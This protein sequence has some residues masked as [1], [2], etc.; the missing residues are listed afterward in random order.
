[1]RINVSTDTWKLRIASLLFAVLCVLLPVENAF[2]IPDLSFSYSF[3][4]AEPGRTYMDIGGTWDGSAEVFN[5]GDEFTLT[6]TNS[7]VVGTTPAY[8]IRD[9]TV[10]VP[11]GFELASS[12]VIVSD[13]GCS[14]SISASAGQSSAG[15]PVTI[16][17]SSNNS[18]VIDLGCSYSFTF[19]LETDTT[20]NAGNP[21]LDYTLRYNTIDNNNGSIITEN[22]S[23]NISVNAGI[24]FVN[25][26]GPVGPVADGET[27]TF[28]V[29]IDN[30]GSGA[31]FDVLFTDILGQHFD[32]STLTLIPI[33]FSSPPVGDNQYTFNYIGPGQTVSLLVT[34]DVAVDIASSTC[35]ELVNTASVTDRTNS[36]VPDSIATVP[37]DMAALTISHVSTSRCVLCS[38]GTVT[39]R[40]TNSSGVD[41]DNIVIREDLGV[42]GL[43]VVSDQSRING[44]LI[45]NPSLSGTEYTWTLAAGDVVPAN[46]FIDL[47]FVVEYDDADGINEDLARNDRTIQASADYRLSCASTVLTVNDSPYLL[48]LDQPL[49]QVTKLA[50]NLDAGQTAYVPL[51]YGHEGD[52]VIWRVQIQNSGAIN[53]QDLVLDDTITS[54]FNIYYIC[55]SVTSANAAAVLTPPPVPAAP[56]GCVDY[57]AVFDVVDNFG[58]VLG[59][60]DISAGG[61]GEFFY[62]GEINAQCGLATN[63]V[64]IQ[65]GC[66]AQSPVGGLDSAALLLGGTGGTTDTASAD[67]STR[68]NNGLS[69]SSIIEHSITGLDGNQ[70]V[71]SNGIVTITVRNDSGGTIKGDS[72]NGLLIDVDLPD[73]YVLDTTYN[74]VT[75]PGGF[76]YTEAYGSSYSGA[77]DTITYTN[78][79][80][81]LLLNN[82][83]RFSLTSS[84]TGDAPNSYQHLFRH[85]DEFTISFRIV[86]VDQ[87][88]F[89]R[90]A[91]IDVSPEDPTT[92]TA[93]APIVP[94]DPGNSL[95]LTNSLTITYDD[96]C[97]FDGGT[98]YIENQ[99]FNVNI[100]D[101]DLTMSSNIYVL[102]ETSPVNLDVT[103]TNNGGQ[104]AANYFV[105]VTFGDAMNVLSAPSGCDPVATPLARPEWNVPDGIYSYQTV[106]MC[107]DRNVPGLGSIAPGAGQA[108]TLTFTVEN[109]DTAVNDDLTFRADV[110]GEI[111]LFNGSRMLDP[112]NLPLGPITTDLDASPSK[113]ITPVAHNYTQDAFRSRVIGFNLTKSQRI[114]CV[115]DPPALPSPVPTLPPAFD[116][117]VTI[118]EDC[119]FHIDAGG[120]FGFETPGFAL[121]AVENIRVTD[122]LPDGQGYIDHVTN[123]TSDINFVPA[124]SDLTKIPPILGATASLDEDDI[125]WEFGP[126]GVP[127]TNGVTSK[128]EWFRVDLTTRILNDGVDISTGINQH[129][130]TSTNVA[131]ATFTAVFDTISIDVYENRLP[132]AIPGFPP[133]TD[134]TI[135]LTVTEPNI[136]VTKQ[137]CNETLQASNGFDCIADDRFTDAVNDGD[138]NDSYIYRISLTNVA[139]VSGPQRAPAYN[140]IST[141]TLG[142]GISDLMLIE[143]FD[144]DNLDNDGDGLTEADGDAD[145]ALLFSS[146]PDNI[147]GN[148]IP[149][150]ITVDDSYSAALLRVD[151]GDSVTFYYRVNPD[152][153]IAPLQT[154]TNTVTMSYDSLDGAYG[155]QNPPQIGNVPVPPDTDYGRARLYTTA[156]EQAN[157]QMIPLVA[158]QKA[159]DELSNTLIGGS[160]QDVVVGEEIR[161]QLTAQLP[162]AN[163]RSFKIRDELP[164]GVRCIEVPPI[165]L[166]TD[167]RYS[168][169]GFDP[170][171]A[172]ISTSCTKSGTNDYVEWDFGDQQL[173]TGLSTRFDF[174]VDF[175][176]RVENSNITTEG[177]L[178]TNGGGVVDPDDCTG[179]VAVCYVNESGAPIALDFAPVS[180]VVR[181]PRITLTK[182]FS[183]GGVPLTPADTVDAGDV[184]TVTV[185]A[186]NNTPDVA[187]YNLRV[188]DAL[189]GTDL[190]YV[191][192]K[193]G[194]NP[195]D[196]VDTTLGIN[197]PIF[198]WNFD[199]A[200][201]EISPGATKTFTFDVRVDV[202]AQPL[203]TIDNTIQAIWDSIRKLDPTTGLPIALSAD[204]LAVDGNE[205]GLRNGV[206]PN[207][208]GPLNNY[209]AEADTFTS[210]RPLTMSK[211]DLDPSIVPTIGAHKHFQI[212]ILLP[213]GTTNNL[214]VT[215]DLAVGNIS[216]VLANNDLEFDITYTFEGIVSINDDTVEEDSFTSFPVENAPTS[217]TAIWIIGKVITESEVAPTTSAPRIVID[218][219]ARADNVSP[220]AVAGNTLQ[221]SVDVDY[222]HGQGG[223]AP[224]L[225]DTTAQVTVE[226]PLLTGSKSFVN[227][228]SPGIA[229]DA[230][231][232]I[233]Y[234]VSITNADNATTSTAYDVN[235]VD[236]LPPEMVLDTSFPIT[237]IIIGTGNV[238]GFQPDPA[239]SPNGPLIWGRGNG[240]NSIFIDPNDTLELTYRVELLNTVE[241]N[242]NLDNTVWFDWTSLDSASSFETDAYERTGAG[243]PTVSDPNTY[244]RT[245]TE[246]ITIIDDNTV[247]KFIIDDSYVGPLS[248]AVDSTVRIGDTV[249]YQLAVTLQEGHTDNVILEDTLPA[250]LEFVAVKE[251]NGDPSSGYD[252]PG[253]G[254]GSNFIYATILVDD[255]PSNGDTGVLTWNLGSITNNAQ[256]D[257]TTTDT[258]VIEYTAR[259]AEGPS[260]PHVAST[261][262]TNTVELTYIDGNGVL[263]DPAVTPRLRDT[264]DLTVLQPIIDAVSK[265]D[266]DGTPASN[267]PINNLAT[268][269][270]NFRL[271]TCN[272]NGLAPAYGI[273]II[274]DLP[275][276]MDETSITGPSNGA[277]QPDVRINGVLQTAGVDYLYTP[278]AGR[279]GLMTFTILSPVNPNECVDIDFDMGFYTD[280]GGDQFWTNTVNL[281]EYWS[282]PADAGQ[283]YLPGVSDNF[284][285]NNVADVVPP[286]KSLIIPA[287]GE[288]TI[289]DTVVYR[290]S[291]PATPANG[292]LYDVVITDTLDPSLIF[293]SASDT[294]ASN[295]SLTNNTALPNQVSLSI[296]HIPAGQQAIIELQARVNNVADANATDPPFQNTVTY[297]YAIVDGGDSVDLD[298]TTTNPLRIVEPD[299]TV[300]KSVPAASPDAGDILIYTLVI[301][302]LG[303]A[304][305]DNYSDAF[306]LSINDTLGLGLVYSG[307]PTFNGSPL[308]EPVITG[309]GITTPQNILW[310][311]AN[312]VDIDIPEGDSVTITYDVLVLDTVLAFQNLTNFVD[313][314]WTS[315]NDVDANERDGS[316]TPAHNDYRATDSESLLTPDNNN[317]TKR[318]TGDTSPV[319]PAEPPPPADNHVRI[320]DIIDFELRLDLQEGT[321]PDVLVTDILPLGF[322]FEETISINGVTTTTGSYDPPASGEGS[323]FVYNSIPAD[324]VPAEGA[325]GVVSWDFGDIVNLASGDAT[326]DTLIIEYRVRV[327]N[328]VLPQANSIPLTNSV[329]LDYLTATVAAP[330]TS[331]E[332]MTV[333]QPDLTVVK[334]ATEDSGNGTVE[335]GE[336]ITYTVEIANTGTT[337]AYDTVLQDI[338]P[339]GLRNGTAT[340]TM[341]RIELVSGT[342]LPDLNTNGVLTTLTNLDPVYDAV[343]GVATWNFDSG[344]ADEYNIPAGQTLRIVYQVQAES[345]LTPGVT[346]INSA[347]VQRYYSLDDEDPFVPGDLADVREIYGPSNIATVSYDTPDALDLDKQNPASKTTASIG[348]PFS[349]TIL[350]P[351][352]TDPLPIVT[353]TALHDV[354]ILDDLSASGLTFVSAEF[355]SG[356][357]PFTPVNTGTATN[358]VIEDITNGIEVLKDEQV[359]IR[360]TVM[361]TDDNPPNFDGE[362]FSNTASYTF[363]Q[364]DGDASTVSASV[365]ADTTADM[366]I[367][368]PTALT[369]TKSG[370]ANLEYGTPGTFTLDVQNIGTGPA[371]DLT[372]IDRL[373]NPPQGGMCDTPPSNFTAQIFQADGTTLIRTLVEGAAADYVTSFAGDPTCELT[374]ITQ[375]ADAMVGSTERLIITYDASLDQDNINGSTLTNHAGVTQWFSWDTDGTDTADDEV[376]EYTRALTDPITAATVLDHEDATN[377]VIEAPILSI[378]KT[379]VNATTGLD[380]GSNATPG[381]TMVYTIV[382][383]NTGPVDA[384]NFSLTDELDRLTVGPA[385]FAPNT[386]NV[387][388]FP[389]TAANLSDPAGGTLGTGLVDI[390]NLS[391]P[392]GSSITIIFETTLAPVITSGTV[393]LNQAQVNGPNFSNLLSNDP[394]VNAADDPLVLG[395]EVPTETLITSAPVFVVEKVSN[396]I[397]DDPAILLAGE[398]LRYTVIVRNIGNENT[399]NATLTDLIPANTSY[400]ANSTTLNGIAVADPSAGVSALEAGMPINSP[401][402]TGPGIL[403][404]DAIDPPVPDNVAVITFDVTVNLGV[405]NGTVLS[406][407][408]FL[409]GDGDG[410]G[411]FVIQPSD[412]PGTATPDDP[413]LNIV[414]DLPLLDVQKT[415][416]ILVDNAPFGQLDPLDVIR[417]TISVTNNG[418]RDATGVKLI[419]DVPIDTNYV[420]NSVYLNGLGVAD[421]AGN[422]PLITGIDISS[423]DLT[424]P[425]PTVDNGTISVGQTATIIFD[426][427]VNNLTVPGT[428]ISNQGFVS[429]NETATEPTDS[430]GDDS[431]GDQPTIIVVGN[432]ET[433]A[434]TKQVSVVGGGPALAGGQLE[435]LVTVSNIGAVA[436]TNVVISDDLSDLSFPLVPPVPPRQANYVVGSALLNG[437]PVGTSY[438]G[439]ILSADYGATYGNLPVGQTAVLRF[440]VDIEAAMLIGDTLTNTAVVYWDSP[441]QNASATVTIDIGGTPGIANLHGQAWHDANFDNDETGER[442]LAGWSVQLYSSGILIDTVQTDANGEYSFIGLAPNSVAVPYELRFVAPGAGVTTA[443]LGYAVSGFTNGPQAITEIVV[444]SGS[445]V[446]DM[447]LPIQPN[448]VIYNSILRTPVA[449]ATL[450]MLR[451]STGLELSSSCFDDS[452]Q[453]AQV[454]LIDG[455]YKFDLNFSQPDCPQ[456]V[457]Y[458]VRVVQPATG[459]VGNPGEPSWII[460]P[461]TLATTV[462]SFDVPACLGSANDVIPATA[463]H[464]EAQNSE[465]APATSVPAQTAGTNYYLKLTL[466]NNQIPGESQL[467]N[468]HIPLDPVLDAALA[469]TKITPVVN[470]TRGQL[471]PYTI[472][473]RNT[474]PV[475]LQ[476]LNIIDTFPAGFKYVPGSGRLNGVA[477]EPTINYNNRTL[478][479]RDQTLDTDS[480]RTIQL[481][482]VVGSGVSEGE[483]VNKVHAINNLT[484]GNAS[485]E[486]MATVRVVPDPTFDCSD[487]IGKVFDDKN[488]NGYQDEGE[489]GIAGARV[490][491]ARGLEATAD[492]H[493][494]FH[495]TC[496]IVPN[497]DRG[498][499]FILKLDERSLPTG[500]R[501][502]TE[503]P[504]VQRATR[505]KMLKYNFGATIHRVVR[506]DMADGVFEKDSTA[507][508]PQW[509]PRLDLLLGALKKAPSIL[510]LSYMADIED[511]DLVEDRLDAVKDDIEDR[512]QDLNCC[513]KLMIE[514]ETFWRRGGPRKRGGFD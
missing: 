454:S 76:V 146:I 92:D 118:G 511:E 488:L 503:N 394:N 28:N 467:F 319:F 444:A 206:L 200:D 126:P 29:S 441:L 241:P 501:L 456:G 230:G 182:E 446:I 316:G 106:Y 365:G 17:I 233:E 109:D 455:W 235:I 161:Y 263:A 246:R 237:A 478:T 174:V 286:A 133:L 99:N 242:Q 210:V 50:R 192:N 53:M 239:G 407:Q 117:N 148:G 7:N 180:I 308:A 40:L 333:L 472:T 10:N 426:V 1:M 44:T 388:S 277:L 168:A 155:N 445:N 498:S 3:N 100:E 447:N 203:E 440:L 409:T 32:P 490:M 256:G 459:F 73:E 335:A 254:I 27:V 399:I 267:N 373:P 378:Q 108:L 278:P 393:V 329:R 20:A 470:V 375:T 150:V 508:R 36:V 274:D 247:Q 102:T 205:L 497:Q 512:W 64:D 215:D 268:D 371:W 232:I 66:A 41:L 344:T 514:T 458:V 105:Y 16:N 87:G 311:L 369:L 463:N 366:T 24:L 331:S 71:G 249:T 438:V 312:G 416:Q 37:L 81:D 350:I 115:E 65:W 258:F 207:A 5:T 151:P 19:R 492:A 156:P 504:R 57:T 201:Y 259:V 243:C 297:G 46:G 179:G 4:A 158:D 288:A 49:P 227:I 434:I 507:M 364:I 435:Y 145:E 427:E 110:M 383:D 143:D 396:D 55:D 405:V 377:V 505:G 412:D 130:F 238:P 276:Q 183:I 119:T 78:L 443:S 397:T 411:A 431:N 465:F 160:P 513:Y 18:T 26:I 195:P 420:L 262:L 22:P 88:H 131:R 385:L 122:D 98:Q 345:G 387:T 348:E 414:G 325:T 250:G 281:N 287:S 167:A 157:V 334:G 372:V 314:R 299:L 368:E 257:T 266:S 423:A 153:S 433:L 481:L 376:R 54:N 6:V 184:L 418:V 83:P 342:T 280:F 129:G 171:G 209:E 173:T 34:V 177:A 338:I 75:E 68:A 194:T 327:Q 379:V 56:A 79:N 244:C 11:T 140:I 275:T 305:G 58:D 279:G 197:Q 315:Q 391:V 217:P 181:E 402:N 178:I 82:T 469:I 354:R 285:M 74:L 190:T 136:S 191:G 67:L 141:D 2:A 159:I 432:V 31:L 255:V 294:S 362:T 382:I 89:D 404:A 390:Q 9:I 38:T 462:A 14:N 139:S 317:I 196:N 300:N 351:E 290:I 214:V 384:D 380:P 96:T 33:G 349:Y 428:I 113:T 228:T 61:M 489:K 361:L 149:A 343:T 163:L 234:T 95:T 188:L 413:T 60:D 451:A 464:C 198:S 52:D 221:N 13:T 439:S 138:T 236:I 213:E 475:V 154:I 229:P 199:N 392:S 424:P 358:L 23:Q 137:V 273:D 450:T 202:T 482:L 219:Y 471:V 164:A 483:Y 144:S 261:V 97:D 295:F 479:W 509:K 252:P 45:N 466:D 186:R 39:L 270:I 166:T 449:G 21:S 476:D 289:G 410:S 301:D 339:I 493:G 134:R 506:L 260:I 347:Q 284:N 487:V 422:S 132:L 324:S 107:S 292:A 12:S 91:D 484:G 468:N 356:D 359:A 123:I 437:S 442:L 93:I 70:P 448:G 147:V 62:V 111:T 101:L 403:R 265:F 336:L 304:A 248:T 42:S 264:A 341:V 417:Y 415:V 172:P 486:A 127:T 307:N 401:E 386:L 222:T 114:S 494:R 187:A 328:T 165:N 223:A 225:T 499:N 495:I 282:L 421:V 124:P 306:D 502:T 77:I 204:G 43:R 69:A 291:V 112:V 176:A 293:V 103:V 355:V 271:R 491:T 212:E 296:D 47:T 170:G 193:G 15:N 251:V 162:V 216:Y 303:G 400:V 8:D 480:T 436:A 408:A 367:V 381:D 374:I 429:S 430:D 175:V 231:D 128:D 322:V 253:S 90:A 224:T 25:K 272:T 226:E 116:T 346:L 85:G 340:I 121:I 51:V 94:T 189:D 485:G 352:W 309:D 406:N 35:S 461:I 473:V 510:R 318:R 357:V 332:T 452:K 330:K 59:L 84:T 321:A 323:N 310:D 496:A 360:I 86:L 363:N 80:A 302:A 125:T 208:G 389:A 120:W 72:V 337:P 185:T 320:G 218:Y 326:T 425:L 298:V 240:D 142:A 30:F 220:S 395:D 283:Q 63:T 211:T 353:G 313:V 135:D 48:A 460:P 269:I 453:Q 245:A 500:F 457:D 152:D 104:D 398:T 474:L 419:D 169:A 477:T 370:P